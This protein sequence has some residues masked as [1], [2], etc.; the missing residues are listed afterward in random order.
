MKF[1]VSLIA[2]ASS[3]ARIC[4]FFSLG[5]EIYLLVLKL[6]YFFLYSIGFS[7]LEA[8]IYIL[9]SWEILDDNSIEEL[10]KL[11]F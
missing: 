5:Q 7:L 10:E 2:I 1:S 6:S 11:L 4:E 9:F 3:N 8:R